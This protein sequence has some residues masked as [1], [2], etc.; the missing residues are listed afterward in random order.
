ME[1]IVSWLKQGQKYGEK[2]ERKRQCSRT[3]QIRR[4]RRKKQ[5]RPDGEAK[6]LGEQNGEAKTD[7]QEKITKRA[8][9]KK[10]GLGMT[11]GLELCRECNHT[12]IPEEVG[13]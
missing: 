4:L 11:K 6:Q 10:P 2:K 8:K 13:K 5:S 9:K 7:P 12:K 3:Q 1:K